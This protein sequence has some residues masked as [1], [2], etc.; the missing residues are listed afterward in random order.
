[1]SPE[2]PT[3]PVRGLKQSVRRIRHARRIEELTC[4][5]E[6]MP[7]KGWKIITVRDKLHRKLV[8]LATKEGISI[9]EL[10]ESLLTS[11]L[12]SKQVDRST[13][14]QVPHQELKKEVREMSEL[15]SELTSQ[16]EQ[17]K[18]P[19]VVKSLKLAEDVEVPRVP[20]QELKVLRKR[21]SWPY[22]YALSMQPKVST[23]DPEPTLEKAENIEQ[24]SLEDAIKANDAIDQN[25]KS[26]L[27]TWVHEDLKTKR[28]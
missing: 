3:G 9:G 15:T 27:L 17:A 12:T 26:L 13:R 25:V 4:Q 24:P 23:S 16:K 5:A 18:E 14:K 20:K 1:L 7:E 19:L 6:V 11:Q 22:R 10:I 2:A 8:D 28:S 21:E